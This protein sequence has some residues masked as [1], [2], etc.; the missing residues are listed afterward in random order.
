MKPT[1]AGIENHTQTPLL[2]S[3]MNPFLYCNISSI[4]N[5]FFDLNFYNNFSQGWLGVLINN[6]FLLL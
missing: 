5:D 2:R 3:V 4:I 1:V 6:I